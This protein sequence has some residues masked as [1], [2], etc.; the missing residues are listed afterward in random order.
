M[1][2]GLGMMISPKPISIVSVFLMESSLP[3]KV[4]RNP[5]YSFQLLWDPKKLSQAKCY[6]IVRHLRIHNLYESRFYRAGITVDSHSHEINVQRR[7][8]N[9]FIAG[10]QK[11]SPFQNEMVSVTTFGKAVEETL[12]KVSR[13]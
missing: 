13:S 4:T 2:T 7:A 11:G 1:S 6:P 5:G 3:S 12:M 9:E 8:R 10:E